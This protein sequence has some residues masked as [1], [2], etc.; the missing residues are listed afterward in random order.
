MDS[1]DA[2]KN[3]DTISIPIEGAEENGE[4]RTSE[5]TKESAEQYIDQ[6]Q[7]LQAEFSNYRRRTDKEKESLS[8]YVKGNLITRL[9]PVLDDFDLLVQHHEE[10]QQCPAEA[11]QIIVQKMKKILS[12]EGLETIDALNEDF[13]PEI[14]EAIAVEEIADPEK[15]GTILEEWQKGY[16]FHGNL[17]RPSRVKVAK[18]KVMNESA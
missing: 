12:D 18:L 7:R 16:C 9:L 14:H 15:E 4:S 11:I 3:R 2:E 10:D 8:T 17:L 6:L 1:K 13:N 5:Q